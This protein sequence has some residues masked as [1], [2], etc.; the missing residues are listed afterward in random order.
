MAQFFPPPHQGYAPQSSQNLQ[1][2]TSTYTDGRV[3][4]Q[5]TPHQAAYG[6]Y[7]GATG[8]MGH[9]HGGGG[10]VGV[11]AMGSMGAVPPGARGP[12]PTGWL[13]AFGTSG[14]EDEPPLLEELGINFG[15]IKMKVG[16]NNKLKSFFLFSSKSESH[17]FL[18]LLLLLLLYR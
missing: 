14:Y 5:A 4:G 17:S 18:F 2:Y 1:F 7:P 3:S 16:G 15:H 8:M 12:L 10:G 6:A 11:S 13:A 9:I